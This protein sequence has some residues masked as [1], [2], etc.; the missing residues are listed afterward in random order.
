MA[1]SS[2]DPV[3]DEQS[4]IDSGQLKS[5]M[6]KALSCYDS[7][8]D[9]DGLIVRLPRKPGPLSVTDIP[10]LLERL[11]FPVAEGGRDMAAIR[12]AGLP[13][14]LIYQNGHVAAFLPT[15]GTHGMIYTDSGKPEHDLA[16]SFLIEPADP[17]T[18]NPTE[19]MKKGHT[20]D[21]FWYPM[22]QFTHQYGEI[23]ACS[24]FLNIMVLAMPMFT[25]NVYDRVA[26]NYSE[27][28]LLVLTLGITSALIFDF[29]F[30]TTRAYILEHVAA[31]VGAEYDVKL[32][33][34]M[35]S[36][37]AASMPLTLGERANIFRELQSLKDFYAGKLVP[38]LVDLPFFFLFIGIIYAISPLLSFI[39]VACGVLIFVV[40]KTLSAPINRSADRHF[41]S[42]QSKSSTLIQTLAGADAIKMHGATGSRLFQWSVVSAH[43]IEASRQNNVLVSMSGNLCIL[44]TYM[45]NVLIL[46]V[47]VHEIS[48]GRLTVGG[49][50]ACS[51]LAGRAVGPIVSL[52]GLLTRLKQSSD[53]LKIIDKIFLLPH[54]SEELDKLSAKGPLKGK[55][56]L[57]DV[58][59][60]YPGQSKPAI[61][62]VSLTINPGERIGLIGRTGAGKSTLAR[63]IC[64]FLDPQSGSI[65]IDNYAMEAISPEELRRTI[66]YVP[67]EGFFFTGSIRSNILLGGDD[68]DPAVLQNATRISGLDIVMQNSGQGLDMEVGEGG[69]NLSCG[70]RQALALARALV[71]N[72]SIVVFDEPT[73]GID[74][75]LEA[76]IRDELHKYL[77]GR[78]FIMIT[79]RTSLLSLV[80][81]LVM[82]DRGRIVADGPREEIL[83]KIS[84]TQ[85]KVH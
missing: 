40:T 70:Q 61:N 78:T 49:V 37:R 59:F 68:V 73:N 41:A 65:Y 24:V 38:S 48:E 52:S 20:L 42:M 79:H 36:I 32:M 51:L 56:Q 27:S 74:N 17:Q 25:M 6:Q 53:V 84:G 30:R 22:K 72:P 80:D 1:Q 77:A 15:A 13:A 9:I 69:R 45:V 4:V 3:Q 18:N 63:A 31:R 12:A 11:G 76:T 55:I 46:F 21:W 82:V 35:L 66:G 14:I 75:A 71:R 47:G 57:T 10:P 62:N 64:R 58:N 2:F 83:K 54:E 39:P 7:N 81:R 60:T 28:T 29:M 85:T 26:V 23:V 16:R 33:E 5:S 19:H 67:Q 34:R 50:V 43:S 44:I 8:P